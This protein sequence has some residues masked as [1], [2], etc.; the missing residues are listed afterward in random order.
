MS[1]KLKDVAQQLG[2]SV[3]TVS[4]VV[5]GKDRVS[6]ST[7]EAVLTALRELD[8]RPNEMA[9]VLRGKHSR[10][11]GVVVSDI[12]NIFFA[13]LVKGAENAAMQKG[14]NI[15]VCNTDGDPRREADGVELLVSKNVSGIIMAAASFETDVEK[16][17]A[18]RRIPYIYID[19]MP[20][21]RNDFTSVSI[22]NRRAAFE[23]NEYLTARG[24]RRIAILAG[25]QSESSGAQR[26][27]GWRDSMLGAGLEIDADI[28][29]ESD[30]TLAAGIE[31]TERLLAAKNRPT[32]IFAANNNLAYGALL[33]LRRHGFSVPGDI[34]VV[35]FDAADEADLIVPR[36]TSVLQPVDDF[37]RIAVELCLKQSAQKEKIRHESAVQPY[38]FVAGDSVAAI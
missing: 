30:F 9:R 31:G 17:P 26:L 14:Y 27:A 5:N 13:R 34:S 35:A 25:K 10:T 16:E 18:K 19:N 21:R 7:R 12:S 4:R 1:S 2:V 33:A 36:I 11:I 22:D 20:K 38:R 32:A 24:H 29:V 28:V 15:L 23:L 3:S 6:D 37:G 8:Y